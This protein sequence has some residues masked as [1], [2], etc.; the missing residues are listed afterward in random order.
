MEITPSSRVFRWVVALTLVWSAGVVSQASIEAAGAVVDDTPEESWQVNGRVYAT[1]IVGDTVFVGGTFTLAEGPDGA[2]VA[3]ENVAAFDMVTGELRTAWRADA[4][5]V[6]RALETDGT[7]LYIGGGFTSVGGAQ[8]HRLAKVSVASGAVDPTFHPMLD[9]EVR[10]I[11]VDGNAVYAGGRFTRVGSVPRPWVAKFSRDGVLDTRFEPG[12]NS[13]VVA[14]A[15][16]PGDSRLYIGGRF[17][18]VGGQG[19][20][21]VA[22]LDATTGALVGPAFSSS[23][24]PTLGLAVNGDG[25]R[26]YGAGGSRGPTGNTATAWSTSSGVRI[27]HDRAMGDIQAIEFFEDV[28][29]FGFHAGFNGDTDA[30]VVRVNAANGDVDST[31]RPRFDRFWGV[32]AI[33]A[34]PMGVVVG[35]EFNRVS[36]VRAR[37]WARFLDPEPPPVE[38]PPPPVEP[39]PVEPPPPPVEPPPPPVEPPAPVATMT[40]L[41]VSKNR[42]VAG[43]VVRLWA[44]VAPATQAGGVVEIVRSGQVMRTVRLRNGKASVR[45]RLPRGL[46]GLRAR[47][48]GAVGANASASQVVRIRS[49]P[50]TRAARRDGFLIFRYVG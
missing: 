40:T 33:D 36:D 8:R 27:W 1:Q 24:R 30:K 49:V 46:H 19:R 45:L 20:E 10:A 44:S 48:P 35:G 41:A 29:Y 18:S 5:G 28:V 34:S 38:P 47:Y 11:E 17:D 43:S 21:G 39:P 12:V 13:R 7:S 32:L 16:A 6:V 50:W 22:G 26:L 25:S 31:Y 4:P 15:K 14:L 3:R 9:G 23:A 42:M 37:N 2:T